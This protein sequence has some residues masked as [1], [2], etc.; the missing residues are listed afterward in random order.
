MEKLDTSRW[1]TESAKDASAEL[2]NKG[3][4]LIL[5]HLRQALA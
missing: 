4:A 1:Y 3:A 5:G 2:G